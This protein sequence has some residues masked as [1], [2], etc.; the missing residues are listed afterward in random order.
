MSDMGKHFF[1]GLCTMRK[2]YNDNINEN[3]AGR[4]KKMTR[5]SPGW[6]VQCKCTNA[7]EMIKLR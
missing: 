3:V 1:F 2:A 5:H 6:M 4:G 7:I